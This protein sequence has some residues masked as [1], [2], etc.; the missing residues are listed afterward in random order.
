MQIHEVYPV[1]SALVTC[2]CDEGG[3]QYTQP[4]LGYINSFNLKMDYVNGNRVTVP[5]TCPDRSGTSAI[6]QQA[7]IT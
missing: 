5:Y 2:T 4:Y 6:H 1:S 3:G 7:T